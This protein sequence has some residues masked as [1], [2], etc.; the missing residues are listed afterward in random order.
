MIPGFG[1]DFLSKTDEQTSQALFKK[2]MCI[3]DSMN[4]DGNLFLLHLIICLYH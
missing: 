1:T 2:M 3:M 4:D